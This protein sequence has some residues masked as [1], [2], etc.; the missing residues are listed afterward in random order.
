MF[1]QVQVDHLQVNKFYRINTNNYVY[2]CRFK[3][4]RY[5]DEIKLV[6]DGLH[7]D[8]SLEVDKVH[9]ITAD[10]HYNRTNVIYTCPVYEFVSAN[11]RWNM[12]R[13]SVNMIVRRL[14]GDEYFIW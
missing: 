2:K 1:H 5:L 6:F 4:F 12:E 9:N 7:R 10:F 14:I 13:R 11:P 8:L 3:G